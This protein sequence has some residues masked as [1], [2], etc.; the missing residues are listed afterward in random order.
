[1]LQLPRSARLAAWGTAVLRGTVPVAD[2]VAAIT[3]DDEPHV[4]DSAPGTPIGTADVAGGSSLDA[5]GLA[6]LLAVLAAE[7]VAGLRLVLPAPG[8]A[9]GLPGPPPFNEL[10]LD[11]GEC[12][13]GYPADGPAGLSGQ[14]GLSGPGG[15]GLIP[16]LEVF[17]S[18]WEPGCY[19]SWTVHQ[20][21]PL[22]VTDVG[23]LAEADRALREAL[24][25]A[26]ST[27]ASLD[28]ARWRDDA[29]DRIAA[30]RGGALS[31]SS[32]P[33]GVAVRAA[34]VLASAAR[35]RAIVGLAAEDDGAAVSSWE[36]AQRAEALRGLDAVARRGIVAGVNAP[37][38]PTR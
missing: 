5:A 36:A 13:L 14:A 9:L 15:R 23:S 20:V 30:V 28:V 38:E 24:A 27:L 1:M 16:A 17:G 3:G 7:G 2:A 4:V 32:L 22:R 26:T 37:L 18:A 10:A 31:P 33:P 8:D 34:Q 25:E 6:E 19:V 29:A 12:V 35:V 21:Q 11:A